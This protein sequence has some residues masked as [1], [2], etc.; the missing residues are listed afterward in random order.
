MGSEAA[1]LGKTVFFTKC[2]KKNG[3]IDNWDIFC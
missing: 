1:F 2:L 3:E